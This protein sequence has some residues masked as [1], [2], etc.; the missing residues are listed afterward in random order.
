MV[1]FECAYL[2]N[3]VSE[4]MGAHN[5]DVEF[6]TDYML[7]LIKTVEKLNPRL[8]YLTQESVYETINRVAKERVSSNKDKWEDWIDLVIKYVENSL[9]GRTHELKGFEGA[10]EFFKV[11]KKNRISCNR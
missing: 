4:L 1:I 3:H 10:I 7:G 11:R 8:I 2:Q 9:Y 5:K 6:I